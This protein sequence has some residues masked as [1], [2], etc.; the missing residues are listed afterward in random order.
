MEEKLLYPAHPL[1]HVGI[2][3][4]YVEYMLSGILGTHG[5][6]VRDIRLEGG[7]M[8]VLCE[9]GS[10]RK[11]MRVGSVSPV[12]WDHPFVLHWHDLRLRYHGD[13]MEFTDVSWSQAVS[14]GRFGEDGVGVALLDSEN[15]TFRSI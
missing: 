13:W 1:M 2:G 15:G 6:Y 7:E 11:R 14:Y 3:D 10:E 12:G 5:Y 8:V 9:N 4:G